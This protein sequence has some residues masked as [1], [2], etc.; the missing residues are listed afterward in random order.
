MATITTVEQP[1]WDD[2]ETKTRLRAGFV[3]DD[4]RKIVMSFPVDETNEEYMLFKQYSSL[5][6]A[7][8]NTQALRDQAAERREKRI[9]Q[10]K[11]SAEQKRANTLFNVKVEAFEMPLVQQASTEIKAKIR[12]STSSVEVIATV[13]ALMMREMELEQSSGEPQ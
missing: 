11:E 5:E 4:G 3:Y 8:A 1:I 10:Q 13:A 9:A 6:E 7:D 12:K 2:V